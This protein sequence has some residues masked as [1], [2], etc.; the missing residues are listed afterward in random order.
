MLCSDQE[1]K[2]VV[3]MNVDVRNNFSVGQSVPELESGPML[4]LK[5]FGSQELSHSW[6]VQEQRMKFAQS[7]HVFRIS[8]KKSK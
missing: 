7:P 2:M 5:L 1:P 4:T 8:Q 6:R 3:F